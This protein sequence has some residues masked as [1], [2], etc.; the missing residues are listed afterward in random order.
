MRRDCSLFRPAAVGLRLWLTPPVLSRLTS[1]VVPRSL[2]RQ[3]GWEH[4]RPGQGRRQTTWVA[5][6]LSRRRAMPVGMIR[7]IHWYSDTQTHKL[8]RMSVALRDRFATRGMSGRWGGLS[9][10]TMHAIPIATP[11][12]GQS[13]VHSIRPTSAAPNQHPC[14]GESSTAGSGVTN[15]EGPAVPSATVSANSASHGR[16]FH[17]LRCHVP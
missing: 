14:T 1:S 11:R 3:R 13:W 9:H 8:C 17:A 4:A 15:W 6:Q 10:C 7:E 12:R 5:S 2:E 16:V